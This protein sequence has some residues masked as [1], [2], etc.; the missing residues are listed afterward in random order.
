MR[1][2]VKNK[3]C[4]YIKSCS[5]IILY[6]KESLNL[7]FMPKDP[8]CHL[9]QTLWTLSFFP[10]PSTSSPTTPSF[11][12]FPVLSFSTSL[13]HKQ[14]IKVRKASKKGLGTDVGVAVYNTHA[15]E[16]GGPSYTMNPTPLPRGT[17]HFI[18]QARVYFPDKSIW[19]LVRGFWD[20][21]NSHTIDT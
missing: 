18:P 21:K 17:H 16:E 15:G 5:Y 13:R 9:P 19:R 20:W 12:L 8:I 6:L 14:I 10:I 7:L 2:D 1:L 11:L 3:I 4:F